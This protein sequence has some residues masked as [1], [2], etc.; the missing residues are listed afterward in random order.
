M[1]EMDANNHVSPNP[2]GGYDV[3]LGGKYFTTRE[4]KE[5]AEQEFRDYYETFK[6]TA[7]EM[8]SNNYVGENP[9]RGFDIYV[10]GK[11]VATKETQEEAE[12]EF[13]EQYEKARSGT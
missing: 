6:A 11:H 13:R 9:N 2:N 10:G 1:P 8:D 4:T 3:F 12:R 7:I 5:Q